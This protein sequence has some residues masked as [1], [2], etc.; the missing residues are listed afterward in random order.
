MPLTSDLKQE[1]GYRKIFQKKYIV[2]AKLI[3]EESS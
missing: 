1:A 3:E 2:P